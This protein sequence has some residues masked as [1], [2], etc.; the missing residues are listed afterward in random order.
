[1]TRTIK[2]VTSANSLFQ[3]LFAFT[4]VCHNVH[5][6][7]T[8]MEIGKPVILLNLDDLYES[9]YDVLNQYF[10]MWGDKKFVDLGLGTHRVKAFVND[11]FRFVC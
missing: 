3:K 5:R 1:M 2:T 6:I 4:Q 8:C 7:K 10:T 11:S 9:L